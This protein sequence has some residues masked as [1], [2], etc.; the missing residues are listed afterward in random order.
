LDQKLHKKLEHRR[1]KGTLRSLSSFEGMIDFIS[2]D[3][4]GLSKVAY[5]SNGEKGSTGSRLI[6]GNS[7]EVE[8][9]ERE[10]A[11][12][13]Q[14]ESA[15]CFNSGYDANLGIFSSVPQKGDVVLYDEYIHASVRDGIRLSLAKSYSFRHN[16]LED[17][18]RLLDKF[19]E[20]TVYVAIESLYSMGGDFCPLK[21]VASLAK[22]YG[23]Y[24]ILDEAHSAGI[25]GLEGRGFSNEENVDND[26]FIK[27]VTFG[28]AYG[29]HG[30]CVLMQPEMKSFLI[31][32][33]RS[34]IYS[35]ALPLSAYRIMNEVVRRDDLA[36]K[37]VIL[38]QNIALFRT[39]IPSIYLSSD[40]NSPIQILKI[41]DVDQ[42][43]RIVSKATSENMAVKA[44]YPPTV[45][46]GQECIRVCLHAFNTE[47]QISRFVELIK[48]S[49]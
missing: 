47:D 36:S 31:N 23:A 21:A 5:A 24:V 49:L 30:A 25:S 16:D 38:L 46:P 40:E 28:K 32:F 41:G 33:A 45:Q 13:F 7:K 17:L 2:N 26:L 29:G 42:M 6:S 11:Q 19:Q 34:F 14:W 15:L 4:L 9:I 18:K 20:Q 44:I 1:E 43:R 10:L 8:L 39:L 3:Y 22:S 12:F 48:L 27:L 37:R 35:T